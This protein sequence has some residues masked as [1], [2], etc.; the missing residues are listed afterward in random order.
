MS[1][2]SSP[3]KET[4]L[5]YMQLQQEL[6]NAHTQQALGYITAA[7][8]FV[9]MVSAGKG[10]LKSAR[11]MAKPS[12]LG[13]PGINVTDTAALKQTKMN[14]V[15]RELD[16]IEPGLFDKAENYV[17]LQNW[18]RLTGDYNPAEYAHHLMMD[19][20]EAGLK[21]PPMSE[22]FPWH[23][24][25]PGS[26]IE[27]MALRLA[28]YDDAYGMA[29]KDIEVSDILEH[30][31]DLKTRSM[32]E[33]QSSLMNQRLKD[34]DAQAQ[35]FDDSYKYKRTVPGSPAKGVDMSDAF[36]D[37]AK[38][39]G[40]AGLMFLPV[41]G[42]LYEGFTGAEEEQRIQGE[43]DILREQMTDEERA[44]VERRIQEQRPKQTG[45]QKYR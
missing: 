8:E 16:K 6:Q 9:P 40:E 1:E 12:V 3:D 23:L 17:W 26:E 30:A 31:A 36:T 24:I 43:L 38:A 32:S 7:A 20:E 18:E 14:V 28:F 33:E 45:V 11:A 35:R 22:P 10:L 42:G 27:D 15:K 21:V 44:E 25:E 37:Y 41:V 5:K 4:I 19:L 29:K 34:I 39:R 2:Q 13:S